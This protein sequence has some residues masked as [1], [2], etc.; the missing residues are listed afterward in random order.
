MSKLKKKNIAVSAAAGVLAAIALTALLCLPFAAAVRHQVLSLGGVWVWAVLAA[1]L[2]V[3]ISTLV[4][5][6]ARQRQAL[7]TG[8]CIA[9]GVLLSAALV[10]ALGGA[11]LHFGVR[12]L[13][14]GG[15]VLAGG[16]LGAVMSIRQNQHKKRRF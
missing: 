13:W 10:C 12:F 14:L 7:P 8:G 11:G 9:G 2:S 1:G 4:I 3:F 16:M 5:A 6:R 15:A